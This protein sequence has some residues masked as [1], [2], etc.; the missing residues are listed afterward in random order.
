M[1]ARSAVIERSSAAI[2]D[3][4]IYARE[5][6]SGGGVGTA[7]AYSCVATGEG[8]LG[9]RP[10][11]LDQLAAPPVAP[12]RGFVDVCMHRDMRFSLGFLKSGG[13]YDFGTPSAV[14]APGAGGS[15]ALADPATGLGYAYVTN[16]MGAQVGRDPR[17]VA[18]R[19]ALR[20]AIS[21]S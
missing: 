1:T 21:A 7:R 5:V 20:R 16:R 19:T 6:P 15:F 11:V 2:D 3:D 12:T 18:V 8:E 14:G 17:E 13:F 9:L 4:R 10:E